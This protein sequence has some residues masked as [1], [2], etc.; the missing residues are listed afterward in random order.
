MQY[1]EKITRTRLEQLY[2]ENPTLEEFLPAIATIKKDYSLSWKDI[3]VICNDY[4]A[5]DYSESTYRKR[6]SHNS[7]C[8]DSSDVESS[9]DTESIELLTKIGREK[10]KLHDENVQVRAYIRKLAREET[11]KE[12]ALDAVNKMSAKKQLEYNPCYS[13]DSQ[14]DKEGILELSDW[15]F[16]IDCKN[17]WNIYNEEV[18][19]RRIARLRDVVI[20]K[21]LK[22]NITK[23]HVLN[24]GDMIAGRI[25]LTIML[26]SRYDVITQIMEV[27][28]LLCEFLNDLSRHFPIEYYSCTD[29]HSRLEPKK[30]AAME[31]ESLARITDWYIKSRLPQINVHEN[32][33]GEDIITFKCKG[34]NVLGIHGNLD[35]PD[36]VID[37][38]SRMTEDHYDLICMV[39]RHHFSCDEKNRTVVVANSSL[40]GTD[41]YA[42]NLRLSANPSQN[43]IIVSDNNVTDAIYRILL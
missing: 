27:S 42:K 32:K 7:S 41:T 9:L 16:G 40:M 29:N 17:A 12:I 21:A 23:L 13:F 37:S 6:L 15:H 35:K 39:H 4:F 18:A 8:V 19:K 2:D 26:E 43:L 33:F 30:D 14:G 38:I 31:S 36:Q 22:D 24:L 20:D 34:F 10:V 11:Y 28:E 3:A 5:L 25:H 1:K